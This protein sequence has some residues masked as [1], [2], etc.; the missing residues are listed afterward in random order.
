MVEIPLADSRGEGNILRRL[1][2]L[3]RLLL[4]AVPHNPFQRGCGREVPAGEVRWLLIQNG[5]HGLGASVALESTLAAEHFVQDA[6]EAKDIAAIVRGFAPYLLGRH[7]ADGPQDLTSVRF[8]HR[9]AIYRLSD[10]LRPAQLR[11]A[12]I[13]NFKSP[14]ARYEDVLWLKVT[15]NNT[16]FVSCPQTLRKLDREVDGSARCHARRR[17]ELPQR[18]ALEELR[19]DVVNP[20]GAANVVNGNNIGMI[21]RGDRSR[22]L[23]KSAQSIRI[24]RERLGQHLQRNIAQQTSVSRPVHFAHTTGTDERDNF[25]RA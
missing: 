21:Q 13:Q 17:N 5:G 3:T 8:R 7:V 4:D 6:A 19:D 12:E 24:S 2:P 1:K 23:L 15:M 10:N 9:D 25:V 16:L 14:V 18:F 11:Q 20:P 22:L